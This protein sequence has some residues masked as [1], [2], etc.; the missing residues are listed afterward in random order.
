[1]TILSVPPK[2]GGGKS[3][4]DK[5]DTGLSLRKASVSTTDYT[6]S[7][8]LTVQED[9]TTGYYDEYVLTP[10]MDG[11]WGMTGEEDLDAAFEKKYGIE[12]LSGSSIATKTQAEIQ[13]ILEDMIYAPG[14]DDLM[15]KLRLKVETPYVMLDPIATVAIGEPL[16]VT[17]TSNRQE[18]YVIVV[19][20]NGPVE[21][22]PWTVKIENGAFEATF[23]TTDAV[24][25]EY[26]V[27]ADD[28]DGHV[29]E[30]ETFITGTG[31]QEIVEGVEEVVEQP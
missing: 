28:G 25:G 18:G 4:L 22:C 21:L 24:E 13:D 10:G 11:F 20:C 26:T 27:K 3:L 31:V 6:Y 23:D 29:A 17:G 30:Q 7:K 1:V 8:K 2:G 5:G 15:V 16:V 12:D 19:T 9:A 14:S